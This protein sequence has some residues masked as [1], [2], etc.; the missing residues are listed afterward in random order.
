MRWVSELAVRTGAI[1]SCPQY[2]VIR[3]CGKRLVHPSFY[4]FFAHATYVR[5]EEDLIDVPKDFALGEDVLEDMLPE[6]SMPRWEKN[7]H[8]NANISSLGSITQKD[9][10]FDRWC[11]ETFQTCMWVGTALTGQGSQ[12]RQ[13]ETGKGGR[14]STA[15]AEQRPEP[16]RRP[17]TS[18][19][20]G[21]GK[22]T[23]G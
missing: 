6:D 11:H 12:K 5:V 15:V 1:G 23:G 21:K 20:R 18:K 17:N 14:K 2:C 8:G 19:S 16:K 3:K 22:G 9:P 4:L 7:T 13:T 10:A